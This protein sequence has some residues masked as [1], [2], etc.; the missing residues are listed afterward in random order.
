MLYARQ[1][2]LRELLQ[3]GLPRVLCLAERRVQTEYFPLSLFTDADCQQDRSRPDS[4]LTAYLDVH[5]IE[6]EKGILTLK[7]P[8]I[9]GLYLLVEPLCKSGHRGLRKLTSA[10]LSGDLLDSACTHSLNDHLYQRQNQGLLRPLVALK[11][12]RREGAILTVGGLQK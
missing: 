5:G 1:A 9:P 8:L 7:R 2:S 10:K 11:E 4:A 6:N 12:L 3:E